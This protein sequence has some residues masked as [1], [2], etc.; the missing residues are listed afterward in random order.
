MILIADLLD[1]FREGSAL[2]TRQGCGAKSETANSDVRT[3]QFTGESLAAVSPGT[4]VFPTGEWISHRRKRPP[5]MSS[6]LPVMNDEPGPHRKAMA[7]AASW[8]WPFLP[9]GVCRR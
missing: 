5:L 3:I 2:R 9:N 7:A 8:A 4:L 6:R 1:A